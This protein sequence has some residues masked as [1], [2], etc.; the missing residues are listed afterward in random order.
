MAFHYQVRSADS[1]V[2]LGWVAPQNQLPGEVSDMFGDPEE[3]ALDRHSLI[4]RDT[5]WS[6]F[7]NSQEVVLVF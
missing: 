5:T 3:I 4:F 7:S 6:L 2:C 1:K